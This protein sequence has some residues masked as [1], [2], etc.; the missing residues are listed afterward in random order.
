MF[1]ESITDAPHGQVKLYAEYAPDKLIDFL[2]VSSQYNLEQAY[3]ICTERDLV[4][5]MVF[6]LG[7]MGNNKQALYLI[8]DR[9]G[10]VTRVS[11]W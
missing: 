9:L 2:R 6:L 10:D 11:L 5:E 8:I 7:R 1:I 4:P 3:K